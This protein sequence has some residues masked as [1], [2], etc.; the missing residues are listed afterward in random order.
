VKVS[1][2][3][4]PFDYGRFLYGMMR[5]RSF[6]N[7]VPLGAIAVAACLREAG[8]DV[9]VVDAPA[10]DIDRAEVIR[11]LRR[12]E[13]DAIG[14]SCTSI[15]WPSAD[16]TA[17]LL[18]LTFGVPLFIGGP[19]PSLYP[20]HVMAN[21]S[22]DIACIGEGEET[23]VEL[24]A[25][26]AAGEDMDGVAGTVWRAGSE[27][28]RNRERIPQRE[29]DDMPLPAY[30][31]LDVSRYSAP[32]MRVRQMPAVY[33]EM[34]RGCAYA[35][36]TYCTSAL[37]LKNRYRR[38]SPQVAAEKVAKVNEV[39]GAKEIAFVDDDF[40]VGKD[41]I[42]DFCGELRKRGNPV[43][44]SC[45]VRASQVDEGVF[46]AMRAAGCHQILVGME[47]LD[48]DMLRMMNKDLTVASAGACVRAAHKADIEVIGLF[49]V[50]VPGTTPSSVRNSVRN[51]LAH[52]LDVAVFSL[53]R[54]PPNS[55]AY[56]ELGWTPNDY[57][58]CF[59]L[60][61]QAV[62]VPPPY[63]DKQHVEDTY[64]AA[65]KA[66]YLNPGYIRRTAQRMFSDPIK[67]KN[68]T[69]AALTL[70]DQFRPSFLNPAAK[71]LSR[72]TAPGRLKPAGD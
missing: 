24:V 11:Q 66:F 52:E 28:R 25:R 27:L 36:C 70:A 67:A 48:N 14:L 54:P 30:D 63:R 43:T 35:K 61:K 53:Y 17:T 38:H 2:V 26:L 65:Y 39:F 3:V 5:R 45:Y 7:A 47:V 58:D 49:M 31:L 55:P 8:H 4:P 59:K 10:L 44:W 12:F 71:L 13:P 60:Q 42:Y 23:C 29:L 20:D 6:H 46:N 56:E 37:G 34:F 69:R 22:I 16:E 64:S 57:I 72:R 51:A 50:G 21:A 19:H 15:L 1:I 33:M 32:P 40:V 62:F 9:Q 41:W 18:K 68:I